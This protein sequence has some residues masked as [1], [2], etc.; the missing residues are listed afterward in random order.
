MLEEVAVD[1]VKNVNA[2]KTR[3]NVHDEEMAHAMPAV[4]LV[5]AHTT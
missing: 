3:K 2:R 4:A 5:E 1:N